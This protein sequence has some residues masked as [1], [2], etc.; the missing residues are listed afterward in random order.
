VP[1]A[2]AVFDY[3]GESPLLGKAHVLPLDIAALGDQNDLFAIV[4][5]QHLAHELLGTTVT[6]I[7]AGVD[8]VAVAVEVL[9]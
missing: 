8:Q 9:S 5:A 1:D 3:F 4:V 7:G 2:G 6:V